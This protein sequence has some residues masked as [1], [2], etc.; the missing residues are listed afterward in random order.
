MSHFTLT[1]KLCQVVVSSL[2]VLFAVGFHFPGNVWERSTTLAK[3][4]LTIFLAV[5]LYAFCFKPPG[6]ISLKF[7]FWFA[8]PVLCSEEHNKVKIA[9][10]YLS[11][12]Q[13]A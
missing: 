1:S 11:N 8:P 2:G 3:D 6:I 7:P 9:F 5:L 13:K 12:Q 4:T 10:I